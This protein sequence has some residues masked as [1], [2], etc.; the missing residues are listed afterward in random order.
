MDVERVRRL[1]KL[2]HSALER[3]AAE[4]AAFLQ[5]AC[6]D[7]AG[8]R[9][10]VESL[11]AHDREAENFME[12]PALEM[13]ARTMAP[14]KIQPRQETGDAF[15]GKTVSHY[16]IVEKLGGGGMGVVYKARDTRLRRLVALK[17]LPEQFAADRKAIVRFRREARAASSLNH[18]NICTIYDIGEEA[19]R[20]FIAMEYMD[21]QTLKRVV[22]SR[23]LEN[24]RLLQLATQIAEALD[25]AHTQRIIHRDVKP[26]NIFVTRRGQVKILDFGLAKLAPAP[27][28]TGTGPA[29]PSAVD[30]GVQ[31]RLT[32]PGAAIGTVA[33][34][35]PEQA[36]GEE[37]DVRTDLFSFGA[38]LY[39][40]ATGERAFGGTTAAVVFDAVL[41]RDPAA[42][43]GLN[44][45]LPEGLDNIVAK[46]LRK[47]PQER[48]QSAAEI[49]SDLK[50][51]EAEKYVQADRRHS[52][53]RRKFWLA[54]T[55]LVIAAAF[56]IGVIVRHPQSSK[57]TEKDTV[58]LAD[59]EN[60]TGDAVFDDTLKTG[61][62]VSLRQSPFLNVLS[63]TQVAKTLQLMTRPSNTKLTPEVANELCQ[64]AGSKAY[65]A[66]SI[67]SLGSE[68]V[69]GLDVVNCQSGDMLAQEQ[70]TAVSKEK[71]LDAL[72]G[73]ASKLRSELGESLAT[74]QK[75]DVPLE[76]ATTSSLQALKAYSLGRKARNEK[77][78]A[79]ALPYLH[80][81][82][83]ID[84]NFATAYRVAGACYFNL[85]EQERANDYLT[86]AFQLR[87]HASEREK[88][89]IVAD[90]YQIVTGQL[91]KAAQT[92]Q[93]EIETYPRE[94][95]AYIHLGLGYADQGQYEKAVEVTGEALR[96]AP[97]SSRPY[98]NLAIYNLALQRFDETRRIVHDAQAR[99]L[100]DY[101]LHNVL[102][103]LAFVGAD[104]AAMAEQQQWFAANPEY[105]SFGLALASDT[106][107]YGGRLGSAR[108]LTKRAVDAAL[109]VDNKESGAISQAVAAQRE[110]AFG[111]VT[112]ARDSAAEALKLAPTSQAVESEVALAFAIAGDVPRADSL[113]QDL[114]KRFPL[115]TQMQLL[116]LPAIRTQLALNRNS[117][118]RLTVPQADS[119]IELGNFPYANASCMYRVY[120]RG[121]AYLAS[122]QGS[123]A[124]AEF[125]EILDHSGIVW[126]CWTA[127]LA[128]LGVARANALESKTSRGADA[129]A[130]RGRALAAY[131]DFLTLW[132]NADSNIPILK[133]A[134]AEY[135]RLQ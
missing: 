72:G 47:D 132:K 129:D 68:Y 108:E 127:A 44:P 31:E 109:Q 87:E 41:N 32:N 84:P 38:V 93:E 18:P 48:Y 61:L 53:R 7:D 76:Q 78:N 52:A 50:A 103:A 105:E 19:G 15:P 106:E 35:S 133:E 20:T 125:Q 115:D 55:A 70:V 122:D 88:L 13:A 69:L 16:R 25:A 120:G 59:F 64:R 14:Q 22:E 56:A 119:P 62:I 39:E 54:A 51:I 43:K 80:R 23:P 118:A 33:Y 83:E 60:S 126:N 65:I 77:G 4:R 27:R 121:V 130:A 131:K 37:V 45:Q 57:L 71:V 91:D 90:Y 5:N 3:A 123:A 2:Y 42:P 74:V 95:D 46:A 97:D 101:L 112:K 89:T 135:A 11:L 34:M 128:H 107:A 102:Y 17:F 124:A 29:G 21:G 92:Y 79:A 82:I 113:A 86:N 104:S 94:A 1:E 116:W 9:R 63:D 67:S 36:R 114:G 75:F 24:G 111:N 12:A 117:A 134:K 28:K 10:E 58:V 26:A 40:M 100:D 85:G 49:L 73:A 8:L 66:G 6:G 98:T 81:A 96:L 110:A 99:K 30:L